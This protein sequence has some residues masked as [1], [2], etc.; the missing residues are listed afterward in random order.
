MKNG[1]PRFE[2][3]AV[4]QYQ[5]RLKATIRRVTADPGISSGTLRKKDREPAEERETPRKAATYVA[6]ETCR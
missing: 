2:A 3:D 1:P 4:A 5:S 6:A